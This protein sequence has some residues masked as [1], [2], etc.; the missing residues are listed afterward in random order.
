[1]KYG[2]ILHGHVC[3][4]RSPN[5]KQMHTINLP[6]EPVFNMKSKAQKRLLARTTALFLLHGQYNPSTFL[7]VNP[8]F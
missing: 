5:G 7:F 8:K 3:V 1:M 2:S 4:M 6:G